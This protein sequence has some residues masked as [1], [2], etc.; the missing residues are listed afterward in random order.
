M[1]IQN[2]IDDLKIKVRETEEEYKRKEEA[3]RV[4]IGAELYLKSKEANSKLER[5]QRQ[6]TLAE[7]NLEKWKKDLPEIKYKFKQTGKGK[8]LLNEVESNIKAL[9]PRVAELR[10]LVEV[11]EG[12]SEKI[13]KELQKRIGSK[14][15]KLEGKK[16]KIITSLI[17]EII[18]LEK[19]LEK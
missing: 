7:K 10:D 16:M 6:L 4:E 5:Q 12:T 9:K 14:L 8:D 11:L 1:K 15:K 3:I 17:K 13:N 2:K 19:Q 18:S